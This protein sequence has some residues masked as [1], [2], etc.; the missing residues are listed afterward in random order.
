MDNSSQI[1]WNQEFKDYQARYKLI[2]KGSVNKERSNELLKLEAE[3]ARKLFADYEQVK[4]DVK[5]NSIYYVISLAWLKNWKL[6]VGF[7]GM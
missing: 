4:I 1:H 7:E 6:Y 3:L 2:V 5:P